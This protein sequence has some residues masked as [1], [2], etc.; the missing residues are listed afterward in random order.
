MTSRSRCRFSQR[1][2][3]P[4]RQHRDRGG[5][6]CAKPFP[7]ANAPEN[8][9]KPPSASAPYYPLIPRG[10][11][12]AARQQRKHG[13][14]CSCWLHPPS[15]FSHSQ[16][17]LPVVRGAVRWEHHRDWAPQ[18]HCK[19][20]V[21]QVRWRWERRAGICDVDDDYV[22]AKVEC[23]H[24]SQARRTHGRT[25]TR[26]TRPNNTRAHGAHNVHRAHNAYST[27]T[28]HNTQH[29]THTYST[30]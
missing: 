28:A 5:N 15:A 10:L 17:A 20:D 4:A 11:A 23:T 24:D 13:L 1:D 6:G 21:L 14:A 22:G 19:H 7:T 9:H 16:H 2:S 18:A 27:H 3:S 8:P 29:T 25:L 12:H 30:S 26:G